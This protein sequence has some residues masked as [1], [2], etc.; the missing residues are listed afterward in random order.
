M[1]TP[2]V[3]LG[4]GGKLGRLLS[5]AWP[6]DVV[7]FT[8][9]E[10]DLTDRGALTQALSGA[11]A[12]LCLAG[13]THGADK[14]M[15]LNVT[16]AQHTLDAAAQANCGRVMLASSAAV[17]GRQPGSLTE[18][19]APAPLADY[20]RAKVEMEQMAARHPHPNTCLRI[21]NVAGADAILGGWRPGFELD[22]LD[23]GT[24]PQRSYVGPRTLARVIH[25]LAMV[26]DLPPVLNVA[27][28]GV[29]A[30]GDLLDT[31]GLTW[32]P[33]TPKREITAK[34]T[35]DTARLSTFIEWQP[36]DSTAPGMVREWKELTA[37][38]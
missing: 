30:M 32:S 17:Y 28:P 38:K 7:Q 13:V 11:R 20:G 37:R 19:T 21:G 14:P 16:L 1:T 3:V 36:Q 24:T 8:R 6:A 35:L 4:A 25:A 31:A 23:S 2:L 22:V 33:R 18:D 5:R 29:V 26:D 34:V 12:V 15:S 27:T 10:L 9:T